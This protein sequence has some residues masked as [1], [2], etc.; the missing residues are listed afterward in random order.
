MVQYDASLG[1]TR[2]PSQAYIGDEFTIQWSIYYRDIDRELT[3]FFRVVDL[4]TGEI[5]RDKWGGLMSRTYEFS[6]DRNN[7]TSG[8]TIVMPNKTWNLGFNVG[9]IE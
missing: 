6:P 2:I 5:I 1:I 8:R 7:V 9:H 3:I 4:D